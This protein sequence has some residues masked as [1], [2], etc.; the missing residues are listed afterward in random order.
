MKICLYI[1]K[2]HAK[3]RKLEENAE[4]SLKRRFFAKE[5]LKKRTI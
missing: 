1:S 4:N 2:K 3:T 5:T